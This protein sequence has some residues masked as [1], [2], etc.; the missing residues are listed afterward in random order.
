MFAGCQRLVC[1]TPVRF[2][3]NAVY[4]P[5]AKQDQEKVWRF[6]AGFGLETHADKF[7]CWND[8]QMAKKHHLVVA[9]I[10]KPQHRK[11]ILR[12]VEAWKQEQRWKLSLLANSNDERLDA[13]EAAAHAAT[14]K[15]YDKYMEFI[16]QIEENQEVHSKRKE[17][18]YSDQQDVK[19]QTRLDRIRKGLPVFKERFPKGHMLH[20]LSEAEV[21][22]VHADYHDRMFEGQAEETVQNPKLQMLD[23]LVDKAVMVLART[24]V[25]EPATSVP[26]AEEA[27]VP[28]SNLSEKVSLS[29]PSDKELDQELSTTPSD[30]ESSSSELDQDQ[31]EKLKALEL[32]LN[33]KDDEEEE[34]FKALEDIDKEMNPKSLVS[35]PEMVFSLSISIDLSLSLYLLFLH[36]FRC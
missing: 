6:L 27:Q 32:E 4:K 35:L 2:F 33:E 1:P 34:V 10:D 8:L 5:A 22:A 29:T 20:G 14:L 28:Q 36:V 31:E 21:I 23:S 25:Q 18:E 11:L 3:A 7:Y 26:I 12:K 17:K 24:N 9:G 15:E 19:M 13:I 30:E 16:R